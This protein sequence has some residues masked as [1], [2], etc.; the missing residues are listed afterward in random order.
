VTAAVRRTIAEDRYPLSP[1]LD[2]MNRRWRSSILSRFPKHA[3]N[4]RRCLR[5]RRETVVVEWRIS[6]GS[7]PVFGSSFIAVP[8]SA[9]SQVVADLAQREPV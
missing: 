1:R 4:G 3:L 6:G 7:V 2:P 9:S 8:A 5:R